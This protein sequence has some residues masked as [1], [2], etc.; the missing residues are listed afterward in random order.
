MQVVGNSVVVEAVASVASRAWNPTIADWIM[1]SVPR[2][3][4]R[5]RDLL[6]KVRSIKDLDALIA[7]DG[8]SPIVGDRIRQAYGAGD[9]VLQPDPRRLSSLVRD[10]SG[11][12]DWLTSL[13]DAERRDGLPGRH[14]QRIERLAIPEALALSAEWHARFAKLEADI[15]KSSDGTVIAMEFEDSVRVVELVSPAALKHEGASMGHCVG[16]YWNSVSQGN[17][18]IFSV[19]GQ[20]GASHVTVEIGRPPAVHIEGRGFLPLAKHPSPGHS[21][22]RLALNDGVARQ[23]QGKGNREP[24]PRWAG[25]AA[26]FLD[27]NGW[28]TEIRPG[29]EII[30]VYHLGGQSFATADNALKSI[31]SQLKQ[32][33]KRD[34]SLRRSLPDGFAD[35]LAYATGTARQDTE[36]R[37]LRAAAARDFAETIRVPVIAIG[38][39]KIEAIVHPVPIGSM[40]LV[41][42]HMVSGERD[43]GL[44]AGV[45]RQLGDI[46]DAI[47]AEPAAL[48]GF[49]VA[50]GCGLT[51]SNVSDMFLVTGLAQR[52]QEALGSIQ[53]GLLGTISRMR[54][55]LR[56][57]MRDRRLGKGRLSYDDSQMRL[58]GN[59]L[60]GD[61]LPRLA[62]VAGSKVRG[63]TLFD[64]EAP[65]PK[66]RKI[67]DNSPVIKGQGQ[68]QRLMAMGG[69]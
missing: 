39:D 64:I 61:V 8:L 16:G 32:K 59:L 55:S 53:V 54:D 28:S 47:E 62:K 46:L 15:G 35:V 33:A 4:R 23:V 17:C 52:R 21:R 49:R 26:R 43:A 36:N 27:A 19:R 22:I 38:Q 24:V 37:L 6:R 5:N 12:I 51:P 41:A 57:E 45:A 67:V 25:Y 31:G 66:Q 13:E 34:T 11:V 29:D 14:L 10:V 18:R 30:D 60:A 58:L 20:D 1:R 65:A 48:H 63:M 2:H 40:E 42:A 7:K 44:L 69:R 3:V 56:V 50:P 68:Y 9:E